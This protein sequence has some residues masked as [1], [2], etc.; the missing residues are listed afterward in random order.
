MHT[1]SA[2]L[3]LLNKHVSSF[4][5]DVAILGS[6]WNSVLK[7]QPVEWEMGYEELFGVKPSV[8]GHEGKLVITQ[9]GG[10]RVAV[11][12]GRWHRYEGFSSSEVTLPIR[13][14]AQAGAKRLLITAAAG[15]LNPK[16]QVGDVVITN[17]LLTLFLPDS[18]LVGPQFL[19]MSEVFS[20]QLR[21]V[22]R[23][24]ATESEITFQEGVYCYGHGPHFETPADKMAL[25]MLGADVVGM[26]TIPETMMAR[27]LGLEVASLALVTN[28]AFV[29]HD[30]R[31]VLAAAEAASAKLSALLT[32]YFKKI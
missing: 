27:Q 6:G 15:G 8:P 17:D 20:P 1:E 22:L 11:M 10:K 19:D 13:V 23:Q 25:H 3:N 26:S 16:Y 7:D 21:Q 32:A 12:A 9:I 14:F 2:S 29:K 24:A 18:P 4:P 31:E 30:H 5:E 28:L